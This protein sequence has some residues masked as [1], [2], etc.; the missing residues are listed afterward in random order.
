MTSIVMKKKHVN[1]YGDP[2]EVTVSLDDNYRVKT[3][4]IENLSPR[5]TSTLPYGSVV[6]EWLKDKPGTSDRKLWTGLKNSDFDE[7][8][9][10]KFRGEQE[11]PKRYEFI[12]EVSMFK[13]SH[14]LKLNKEI[15]RRKYYQKLWK[16]KSRLLKQEQ[17]KRLGNLRK[18]KQQEERIK[19]LESRMDTIKRN[20]TQAIMF[21]DNRVNHK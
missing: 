10:V 18:I 4:N 3:I 6:D 5:A 19:E 2:V 12:P 11:S 1:E 21:A 15:E 14:E 17:D 7:C 13:N 20:L 9:F 16:K 8:S